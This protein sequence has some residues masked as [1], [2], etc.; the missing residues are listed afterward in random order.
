MVGADLL[1]PSLKRHAVAY[2]AASI[3]AG[4][5]FIALCAQIVI[6]LPFSPVPVTGQTLAVLL[7]GA[8]LGSRRGVFAVLAYL[9]EGAAGWPVFAGGGAGPVRLLG[10]SGGYL[11]GFVLAAWFAGSLAERGWDRRI[12]TT[13]LLMVLGSLAIYAVAL[14][15]LATFVGW[16]R[17]LALG[18]Y[19]FIVGDL[20][21]VLCAA[22]LLPSAWKLLR[23]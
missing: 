8:A 19:P 10:P 12:G 23:L 21:K 1:R 5:L 14:P 7:V 3:L 11:L 22:L 13:V 17:V 20:A 9:A 15:W 4:S 16:Q 2:D 6:P 18:L